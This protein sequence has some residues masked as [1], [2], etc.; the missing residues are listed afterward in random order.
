ML[1]AD[2]LVL[3]VV[4]VLLV[5]QYIATLSTQARMCPQLLLP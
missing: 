3:V 2:C 1:T 5:V 4:R